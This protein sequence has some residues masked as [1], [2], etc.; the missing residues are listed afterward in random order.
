MESSGGSKG[1]MQQLTGFIRTH[2]GILLTTEIALCILI[3]ICY[4][5]S[6]TL[7]YVS[8][9]IFELIYTIVIFIIFAFEFHLQVSFIHWG[10]TDFL[11]ALIGSVAFLI[12][13]LIVIIG[14]HDGAGVAAGVFGLLVGIVM[15]YDAYTIVPQLKKQH[16][17]V[18]NPD[19]AGGI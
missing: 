8:L 15:G 12:T 13:S 10:W 17:A 6:V 19:S 9:A 2:K 4:G 3:L 11:R 16:A 1:C 18:P 7:G 14:H 5:A